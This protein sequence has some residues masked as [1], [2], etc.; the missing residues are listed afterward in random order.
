MAPGGRKE[1]G[2]KGHNTHQDRQLE[3]MPVGETAAQKDNTSG[4]S[5]LLSQKRIMGFCCCELMASTDRVQRTACWVCDDAFPSSIILG[6]VVLCY[7]DTLSS[8]NDYDVDDNVSQKQ[9]QIV[10]PF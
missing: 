6:L 9:H 1:T 3:F 4:M 5:S 10:R 8:P 7:C 2:D